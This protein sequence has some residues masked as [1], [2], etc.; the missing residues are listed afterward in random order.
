MNLLKK[1]RSENRF[2]ESY[3]LTKTDLLNKPEDIWAKRNHSWSIYYMLKKHVQ[4][5]ETA[6]ARHYL[7]EF[8][9]LQMPTDEILLHERMQYFIK[10]LDAG[11]LSIKQLVS[12][13][14]F[15]EAFDLQLIES[16]LDEEQ[17]A[18][19]VYYLLKSFNKTGKPFAHQVM[20]ILTRFD[21]SY[22]PSKKLVS[23]L[24]LQELIKSPVELWGSQSQVY[25]L[26]RAGG[27]G[28]FEEDDYQKQ[29]WEGK[30][31][32]SLA[33]RLHIS[34]SKAL[35]REKSPTD[36]IQDYITSTVE[37]ILEKHPGM[38]YVPYFKAKLLLGTGD[39]DSGIKAFLPFAKKKAG[40]FW[41]WQVFAEAYESDADL[42]FSCLCKAMTCRT[43]PEFLSNIMERLIA[44][45]VKSE[46]YDL[47]KGELDKL[48]K[49]RE[50]Q[51]W[52][53]RSIHQRYL[54]SAWYQQ[55]SP[56]HIDYNVH[57]SKAEGLLGINPLQTIEVIISHIN[58]DKKVFSFLTREKRQ[59]FGKYF[60]KPEMWK[61]Y[62]INGRFG[63]GDFFEV[64]KMGKSENKDFPLLRSISGNVVKKPQHAFAFAEGVFVDPCL[65]EQFQLKDQDRVEGKAVLSPVKGKKEWAWKMVELQKT[66]S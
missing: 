58:E 62:S 18:W 14:K 7:E 26:E 13:G 19:T 63:K 51:G 39:L 52:G 64:G 3:Q 66:A 17:L 24:I 65:V 47:A 59:G 40:E 4:A 22:Q 60:K 49:L 41:V 45:L 32:I 35:L 42:Y 12:E 53:L 15:Q 46:K 28:I 30:K 8:T 50:N 54:G 20:E 23:K 61:V 1:L 27:F 16:Q 44:F 43:K 55:A 34:Y 38:L 25:F 2:E 5:G 6:H 21:K 48:I 11:Y 36:K 9:T 57:T 37:P 10:V 29:E 56:T 33:E 31:I